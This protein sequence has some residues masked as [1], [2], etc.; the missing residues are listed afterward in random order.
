MYQLCL[1]QV[2][3]RDQYK[4]AA[5]GQPLRSSNGSFIKPFTVALET[6]MLIAVCWKYSEKSTGLRRIRL[7]LYWLEVS[8]GSPAQDPA[9]CSVYAVHE[10]RLFYVYSLGMGWDAKAKKKVSSKCVNCAIIS[11]NV[12]LCFPRASIYKAHGSR[13]SQQI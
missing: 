12:V 9:L 2:Q 5:D 4:R 3:P 13:N 1:I 7:K 11:W 10:S 6:L 8:L